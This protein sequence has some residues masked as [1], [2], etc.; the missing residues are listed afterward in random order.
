MDRASQRGS[1]CAP[2]RGHG[3]GGNHKDGREADPLGRI[4]RRILGQA[5]WHMLDD[6]DAED[7]CQE[8]LFRTWRAISQGRCA[9]EQCE[10]YALGVLR[11]V[12]REAY[13][14]LRRAAVGRAAVVDD[15]PVNTG[16]DPLTALV[17][18]ESR[19]DVEVALNQLPSGQKEVM[20]L[21]L[22][23]G[24]SCAEVSRQLGIP[25]AT[26]RQRKHR[27]LDHLRKRLVAA[28]DSGYGPGVASAGGSG[29]ALPG[30]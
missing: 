13:R 21:F 28:A 2:S 23:D 24:Y 3:R 14:G 5:T 15:A 12:V 16:E 7:A 26:A 20:A 6:D 19:V 18:S 17:R 27:A 25:A 22:L 29:L 30:A 1:S 10:R 8:T 11:N 4:R 9:P